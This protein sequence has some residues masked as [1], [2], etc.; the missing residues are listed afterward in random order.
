ME[1]SHKCDN[2]APRII[3]KV[4]ALD[5]ANDKTFCRD[6]IDKERKELEV[7][8]HVLENGQQDPKVYRPNSG[9]ILFHTKIDFT[10]K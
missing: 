5:R 10:K 2:Q 4:E 9:H 1:T 6:E 3:T 7:E 8:A